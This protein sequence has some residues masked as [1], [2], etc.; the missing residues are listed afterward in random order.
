VI[1]E[2]W[3]HLH[4]RERAGEASLG[5]VLRNG[6]TLV[7][8]GS[9]IGVLAAVALARVIASQIWGVSPTDPATL[10]AVVLV[11]LVVGLVACVFPAR[12]A[13]QVDPLI[14]LRYD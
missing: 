2:R 10:I 3:A 5:M 11:V 9:V 1:R 4:G 12:T 14:A 8:L 6:L 13:T 7:A